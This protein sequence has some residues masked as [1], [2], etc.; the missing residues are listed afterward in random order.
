MKKKLNINI[1]KKLFIFSVLILIK[2]ASILLS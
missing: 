2:N 1:I